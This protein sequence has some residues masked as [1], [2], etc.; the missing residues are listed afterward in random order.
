VTMQAAPTQ[1][2][3]VSRGVGRQSVATAAGDRVEPNGLPVR[4]DQHFGSRARVRH[5]RGQR[6]DGNKSDLWSGLSSRSARVPHLGQKLNG[7]LVATADGVVRFR[8]KKRRSGSG[9]GTRRVIEGI[10]K[11][12]NTRADSSSR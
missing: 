12:I 11:R 4:R 6:Q 10:L 1:L 8:S 5:S 9:R 3:M 2:R 7:T